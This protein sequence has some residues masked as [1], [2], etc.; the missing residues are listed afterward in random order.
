VRGCGE[1]EGEAVNVS[2]G[3][4]GTSSELLFEDSGEILS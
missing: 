1:E 4:E 2:V 3:E